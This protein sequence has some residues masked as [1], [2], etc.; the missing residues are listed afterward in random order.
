MDDGLIFLIFFFAYPAWRLFIWIKD[1]CHYWNPYTG[2]FS[3]LYNSSAYHAFHVMQ[4]EERILTIYKN[5][6]NY[7][8]LDY[9]AIVK[10]SRWM[11]RKLYDS[12]IFINSTY[13][14]LR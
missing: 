6:L 13:G 14:H 11:A 10:N 2:G 4:L 12:N 1:P 8:N 9:S 7:R 5:D 3:A